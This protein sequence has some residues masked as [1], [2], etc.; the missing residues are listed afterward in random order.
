MH[1]WIKRLFILIFIS[2]TVTYAQNNTTSKP[3]VADTPYKPI[4]KVF[5]GMDML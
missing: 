2:E 5:A 3:T 4:L 1:E